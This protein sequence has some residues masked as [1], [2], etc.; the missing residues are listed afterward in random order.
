MAV[1]RWDV[2]SLVEVYRRFGGTYCHHL[3]NRKV[4]QVRQTQAANGGR[5]FALHPL[6]LRP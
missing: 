1:R 5:V 6:A 4:R 3:Q 2:Y